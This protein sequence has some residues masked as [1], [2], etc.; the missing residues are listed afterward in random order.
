MI[1]YKDKCHPFPLSY[2]PVPPGHRDLLVLFGT[3][4][5]STTQHTEAGVRGGGAG[6]WRVFRTLGR[7]R[8]HVDTL[9]GTRAGRRK[10]KVE[11]DTLIAVEMLRYQ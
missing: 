6:A 1:Q 3:A 8:Q 11:I 7:P 9:S 4:Q 2:L 5:H 10:A